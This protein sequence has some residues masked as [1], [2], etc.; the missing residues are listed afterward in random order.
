MINFQHF[1]LDSNLYRLGT[2]FKLFSVNKEIQLAS[3]GPGTS[4][5]RWKGLI[6]QFID[7]S[8]EAKVHSESRT[9]SKIRSFLSSDSHQWYKPHFL[10]ERYFKSP[11]LELF[12]KPELRTS[13]LQKINVDS[14]LLNRKIKSMK[15]RDINNSICHTPEQ[16]K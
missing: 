15:E 3:E 14:N 4:C 12:M 5:S 2:L 10:W 11:G 8:D 16:K 7:Y 13:M 1:V 6:L 9:R